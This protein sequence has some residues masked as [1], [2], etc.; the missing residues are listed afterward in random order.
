MSEIDSLKRRALGAVALTIGFYVLA[1]AISGAL[2]FATY[3]QFTWFDEV[4]LKLVALT[5]VPALLIL[6]SILPR[7]E[8][9][10]VPGPQLTERQQPELFALIRDVAAATR[11]EMPSEVYLIPEVNAYVAY[12]GGILGI[13][14]RRIMGVGLMLMESLSID[15]LRA[16][17]AHEFGHYA[18]DDLKFAGWIYKTRAAMERTVQQLAENGSWIH[19]PF[20]AY[21]R[22]FIRITQS[23]SRAQE[24]AADRLAAS[25]AG[26]KNAISALVAVQRAGF[27]Y[28][29]YMNGE[30]V[31]VLA[32][33][34][35]PP[36]AAGFARFAAAPDVAKNL[37][38][39]M[40][41][42]IANEQ[43]DVDDSHPP[44]RERAEALG[45]KAEADPVADAAPR[46]TSILRGLPELE[47]EL[48]IAV[49]ID[50]AAARKFQTVQWEETGTRVFAPV[51]RQNASENAETLR[52]VTAARLSDGIDTLVRKS[53]GDA[54]EKVFHATNVIGSALAVKLHDLGWMCDATPGQ[55]IAFTRDGRT[56]EPFNV[57]SRLQK[58]EL[59][60]SAWEEQCRAAGIDSV[61]LIT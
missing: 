9:F 19:A 33:G 15:Q 28:H 4:H 18:N 11:Q 23:I 51:W 17:L 52:G 57:V 36:V 47:A 10:V 3:A 50:P 53:E 31:P 21:G 5:L 58:G 55:P 30:L 20:S 42:S 8:R 29:S 32:N 35:R 44:L 37:D 24:I 60:P 40:A 34:Y 26:A 48:L 25:I 45:G 54:D 38:E 39:A 14:S 13:G 2:L 49:W 12:R 16:V 46:A 56:I 27:A 41:D 22:F 1:L 6:W 59:T 61:S 43:T 7:F